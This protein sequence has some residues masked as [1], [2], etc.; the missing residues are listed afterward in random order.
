MDFMRFF[1]TALGAVLLTLAGLVVVRT[2]LDFTR[3]GDQVVQRSCGQ[4]LL[5]DYCV[6]RHVLPAIPLLREELLVEIDCPG[7]R[8]P[9]ALGAGSDVR[10]LGFA[11]IAAELVW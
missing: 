1:W 10:E 2:A 9:Q 8:S 3:V 4:D 7:A 6:E 5:Q 11:L